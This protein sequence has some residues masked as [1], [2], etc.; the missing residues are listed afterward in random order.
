MERIGRQRVVV[1]VSGGVESVVL[2]HSCLRR[3]YWVQPVYIWCGLQWEGVERT[4]LARWLQHLHH[5]RLMPLHTIHLPVRALYHTH[6][7]LTGR[8]VPSQTSSDTA[9]YLPGRNVLLTAAAAIYGSQ[10]GVSTVAL[11]TLG[12]NPFGDATPAFFRAF[13]ACL[14]QALV[15]PVRILTPLRRFTKAQ[16]IAANPSLPFPLTWSCLNPRRGRHCGRCNKCAE[17]RRAFR[18]AHIPDPTPYASF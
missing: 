13:A 1:L 12:G 8:G 17:R 5:P 2:V 4:W 9:V 7:S 16:L 6:W 10:R 3:L 14:R 11:G 15:H 18:A